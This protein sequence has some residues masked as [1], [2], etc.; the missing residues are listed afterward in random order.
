ML[1]VTPRQL[2]RDRL[3]ERTV[4]AVVPPR[5]DYELTELGGTLLDAAKALVDWG[6]RPQGR[7]R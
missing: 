7:Q 6:H 2:E 5:V 3:V 1:T 4:F